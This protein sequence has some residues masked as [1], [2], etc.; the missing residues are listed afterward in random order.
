MHSAKNLR[1]NLKMMPFL[2]SSSTTVI[3]RGLGLST[4][5]SLIVEQTGINEQVWKKESPCLLIY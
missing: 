3:T 2:Y 5:K 1:I 4:L